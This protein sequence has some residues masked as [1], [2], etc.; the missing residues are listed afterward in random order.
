[1]NYI[2]IYFCKKNK[3]NC[4]WVKVRFVQ[5]FGMFHHLHGI[6]SISDCA[7]SFYITQVLIYYKMVKIFITTFIVSLLLCSVC[8]DG[9]WYIIY[10]QLWN[11]LYMFS[12]LLIMLR[13]SILFLL[14]L[15]KTLC[16]VQDTAKMFLDTKISMTVMQ[17]SFLFPFVG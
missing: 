13:Q 2:N 3:M 17:I 11:I 7:R 1:M 15:L 5:Q 14:K 12:S 10:F 8:A 16:R 9:N 6:N 4:I